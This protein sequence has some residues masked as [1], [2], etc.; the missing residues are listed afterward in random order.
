MKNKF[1]VSLLAL[2]LAGGLASCSN[3]NNDK[4]SLE[5]VDSHVSYLDRASGCAFKLTIDSVL[6]KHNIDDIKFTAS[7]EGVV[8]STSRKGAQY[9]DYLFCAVCNE[10][11]EYTVNASIGDLKSSNSITLKV[12]EDCSV[13]LS[14][15]LPDK[16]QV[17][18]QSGESSY[19]STKIGDRYMLSNESNGQLYAEKNGENYDLYGYS[20][21]EW[22]YLNSKDKSFA[23]SS[24]FPNLGSGV[25]SYSEKVE[26]QILSIGGKDYVTTKYIFKS[27]V[28]TENIYFYNGSDFKLILKI[29][30]DLG[31]NSLE[32]KE[33]SLDV[34]SFPFRGPTEN[35]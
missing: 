21:S 3:S 17:K 10:P 5:A 6:E 14:L 2:S 4:F 26:N 35:N 33:I 22:R 15:S 34:A 28:S 11:G 1:L 20:K 24:V 19:T 7:K 23:V 16:I 29:E 31:V 27:L 13:D 25:M 32:V 12:D 18:T 30:D 8:F 9:L